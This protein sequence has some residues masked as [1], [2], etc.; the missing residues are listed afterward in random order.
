MTQPTP[1]LPP[2]R[3]DEGHRGPWFWRLW[4][5]IRRLDGWLLL[6][7]FF[8]VLGGVMMVVS[9]SVP[10]AVTRTDKEPLYYLKRHLLFLSVGLVGMLVLAFWDYRRL[11]QRRWLLPPTL[12]LLGLLLFVVVRNHLGDTPGRTVLP[13]GSVQPGE[14][15][16]PLL[17]VYLAVWLARKRPQEH[18]PWTLWVRVG[19]IMSVPALLL[20]FQPDLS[21][22]GTVVLLGFMMLF[23]SGATWLQVVLTAGVLVLLTTVGIQLV[24]WV[25]PTAAQRI[26]LYT[27]ALRDPTQVT[28]HVQ[29]AFFAFIRGGWWGR[30][31][32]TSQGKV[33]ALPLPH[34]DSVFAVIGEEFGVVGAMVV[35]A[36]FVAFLWRGLLIAARAQDALGRLLAGGL[37]LWL[38]LEAFIHIGGMTGMLPQAGNALPFFSYGGSSLTAALGAVGLILSVARAQAREPEEDG[39]H[40]V[41]DLR[42]RYRRRDISRTGR[43]P[44]PAQGD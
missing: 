39:V 18:S 30:G 22:A 10:F 33:F 19:A 44:A 5:Q 8:M 26:A 11:L 43:V 3:G 16:K 31:L 1:Y 4:Q 23:L 7:V 12:A 15:I 25:Y 28:G 24:S 32:G 17:V 20:L 29:Q 38:V 21:A 36:L 14:F 40:A 6:L 42:R 27:L 37:T 34:T 2:R 13:Q 35:I 41:V 9:A